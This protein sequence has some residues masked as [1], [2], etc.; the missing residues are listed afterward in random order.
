MYMGWA[1]FFS[2]ALYLKPGAPYYKL[3]TG[4]YIVYITYTIIV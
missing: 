2:V 4:T 1:T 3:I